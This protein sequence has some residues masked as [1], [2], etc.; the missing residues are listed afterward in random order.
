MEDI[1]ISESKAGQTLSIIPLG[2]L[3]E[4]GLN[5]M[6]LRFGEEIIVIDAGLMFPEEEMLGVDIVIPDITYL[7]ENKEKVLGL[8]LT[9]GHEDHIGAIPYILKEMNIPIYG[10]ALTLGL[11]SAKLK[12]H[13]LENE[14][15]LT[16]VKPR[17]VVKLG[18]FEVEFIR[19]THSIVDG[20]GFGI[21]TPVGRIVHTGDF[22]VDHTPVDGE[23]LDFH[24]FSY[25]GDQGTLALLSD[26]TNSERKG[27]NLSEREVGLVFDRIFQGTDKRIILATFASNIHRIQQAV[28]AAVKTGR[29]VFLS[30]KSMVSNSQIALD[31]GY[32]KASDSTWVRA[33]E[34]SKIPDNRILII[35]TGSQGEPMSALFRMAMNDHKQIQIKDGDVVILSSRVIPG[36]GRAIARVIDHLYRRGAEVIYEEVSDVHVSGHASQEEQKIMLN[37][38]RPKFFMPIHGEYRHLYHHA[39]LAE[40]LNI[41]K[42]NILILE[43]GDVA[44][45]TNETGRKTGKVFAGRVFVDGKWVGD[46]G[47]LILRDRQ[48]LGTG[49]IIIVIIGIEKLTGT[50]VSGPDIV[51]RG[52]IFE[53][54]AKDIYDEMRY[55]ISEMLGELEQELKSEWVV[56]KSKV[57]SRLRR[58]LIKKMERRPMI[59]P[60]IIEM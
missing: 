59:I 31:L 14:A 49:G 52:F 5:M 16:P 34:L 3:G 17:E 57:Q 24:R 20:V 26:S 9:H 56:V 48:R 4:I 21:T 43:N 23:L 46:I 28:N 11:L 18:P 29:K 37:L 30:G 19:I 2:G 7:R 42:E 51:S 39:R 45:F 1:V 53:N 32:L 40:S 8:F 13:N 60:I 36:N 27:Y 41:P 47:D 55:V 6:L 50:V 38:V 15:I 12:E 10:T 35:T 44:E 33:E 22:K 58:Y 25:Y 54:E